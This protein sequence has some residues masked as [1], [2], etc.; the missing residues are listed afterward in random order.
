MIQYIYPF[1]FVVV[2]NQLEPYVK[3]W[4]KQTLVYRIPLSSTFFEY[5]IIYR[6]SMINYRGF[7]VLA[8]TKV[9]NTQYFLGRNQEQLINRIKYILNTY[10]DYLL[11]Y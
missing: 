1:N 9:S 5:N 6:V 10:C 3:C 2:V 4:D 7:F 8:L 11:Y